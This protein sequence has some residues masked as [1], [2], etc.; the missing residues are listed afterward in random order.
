MSATGLAL[1]RDALAALYQSV[2]WSFPFLEAALPFRSNRTATRLLHA[3]L[4]RIPDIIF[5]IFGHRAERHG[6]S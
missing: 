1:I 2:K 3:D 4:P 6:S 5:K